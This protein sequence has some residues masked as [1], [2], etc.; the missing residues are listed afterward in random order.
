MRF[1]LRSRRDQAQGSG[2][3]KLIGQVGDMQEANS[4]L[5]RKIAQ[6]TQELGEARRSRPPPPT[7]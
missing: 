4:D 1:R 2:F 3:A 7:C 6:L 5:E